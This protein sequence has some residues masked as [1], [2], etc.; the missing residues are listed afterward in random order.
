MK[1]VQIGQKARLRC[2]YQWSESRQM[3]HLLLHLT[4]GIATGFNVKLSSFFIDNLPQVTL[5]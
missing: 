5:R 1:T 2:V 4:K 3:P